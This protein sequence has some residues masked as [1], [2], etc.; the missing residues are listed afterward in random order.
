MITQEQIINRRY[1]SFTNTGTNGNN[2]AGFVKIVN[3]GFANE[4]DSTDRIVL[5]D[6]TT[7]RDQYDGKVIVQESGSKQMMI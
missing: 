5:E 6:E 4:D 3:G 7:S 1:L 2:A